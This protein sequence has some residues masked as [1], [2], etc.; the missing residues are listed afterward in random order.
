MRSDPYRVLGVRKDA[1]AAAI[2]TA[3]RRLALLHHP[4][5]NGGSKE[6]ERRF[7]EVAEAYEILRDPLRR[8]AYDRAQ[9]KKASGPAGTRQGARRAPF[10]VWNAADPDDTESAYEK[11][12]GG[13]SRGASSVFTIEVDW[14]LALLGGTGE[15]VLRGRKKVRIAIPRNARTGDTVRLPGRGLARLVVT[16]GP[17]LQRVGDDIHGVC[18]VGLADAALG[19]WVEAETIDGPVRVRV[20]PGSD[21]RTVLRLE[22]RGAPRGRRRGDHVLRLAIVL[23]EEGDPELEALLRR[24][25]AC[26]SA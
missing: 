7:R 19:G 21:G 25:R 23:P 6:A 18:R 14:R 20:P 24:R 22:G 4:D 15:V 3:Y 8:A 16:Q 10:S 9:E 12:F 2:R 26:F 13:F 1:D 17:A 11:I 5:R